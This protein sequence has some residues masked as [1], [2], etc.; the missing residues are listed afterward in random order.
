[1]PRLA[2]PEALWLL[3]LGVPIVWLGMRSLVVLE[4]F[5][6]WTAIGLRLAVLTVLVS[7]LAGLQSVQRHEHLTVMAVVD[8]SESVRRFATLPEPSADPGAPADA[9]QGSLDY[10]RWLERWLRLAGED[11][12]SDD[13]F[14]LMGFSDRPQLE[15]MPTKGVRTESAR[16][17]SGGDGTDISSALRSAMGLLPP[18][19]G[20]RL[21]LVSDGNHASSDLDPRSGF[22]DVL[23]AAREA[24]AAGIPVDVAPVRY[25]ARSEVLVEAVYAPTQARQGRTVGVRVAL[26][27]TAPTAGTLQLLHDEEM[28]DVNGPDRPGTGLSVA[29]S[30]WTRERGSQ[31]DEASEQAGQYVLV[32][33]VDVPVSMTG[34]NRFEAVFE[35]MSDSSAS[36]ASSAGGDQLAANNRAEGFTLVSGKGKV[37]VV[38]ALGGSSGEVLPSA[39]RSRGIDLDVVPPQGMP[40]RL[41][42]L[43]RYD[44]VVFQNVPRE[45]ITL[46]Q[47]R[48]LVRYVHDL[49]GGFVMVGGNDSFGAGGWTNSPVDQRL[50]PV[51]CQIPTQ[52]V[53]PTGALMLVIDRSGSMHSPVG[54]SNK[55]QIDLASE[56]AVLALQTLYPQDYVGV[57]SF[58]SRGHLVAP[59][60]PNDNPNALAKKIRSI[61]A[62]GGTSITPGLEMARKQLRQLKTTDAAVR[63]VILIT[64]GQSAPPPQNNWANAVGPLM[65]SGIT[66]S[67]VGVGDTRN[68]SLLQRVATMG[69]GE[70]HDI[71]NPGNLPQV[72]I[73]E[74]KTIRKSLIKE[75]EFTPKL[76]ATGSPVTRNLPGTPP[77]K[78]LV[79]TG[80]KRD[81]RVFQPMLGPEGEP[82]FAHWQTGLGRAAA[83]T[84]DAHNRWASDWLAWGGYPDFWGRTI[85]YVSRP[86]PTQSADLLTE[87]RGDRL[88]LRLDATSAGE[89]GSGG[90]SFD[91]YAEVR[92]GVI[93]PDG[94]VREVALEQTGPG[95]YEADIPAD[96]AGSYVVSLMLT[97]PDGTR[98]TVFGGANRPVNRELRQFRSNAAV[99][100]RVAEITGGRVLDPARPR[101]A[102]GGLYSREGYDF[103]TRSVQP[104]W[105]TLLIVLLVL[106]M[107]DVANR[108]VAWDPVG[109]WRWS[110]QRA[111][112]MLGILSRKDKAESAEPTMASLKAARQRAGSRFATAT[113]A[114]GSEG[115]AAVHASTGGNGKSSQAAVKNAETEHARPK[116]TAKFEAALE[117][118]ASDDFASAVGGA[119]AA[120]PT[121]VRLARASQPKTKTDADQDA[122]TTSRLMAAKRA[123][124]ERM[125]EE[126]AEPQINADHRR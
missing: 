89:D 104:L 13:R 5:R 84:S 69:G 83:F 44:A 102:G 94:E 3:L 107:L 29:P 112:A 60:A 4:P 54:G 20:A 11:R 79:L 100:E 17:A 59:L 2:H 96:R 114:A 101:V 85:R 42:R 97:E 66:V 31:P 122:G 40:S 118:E 48:N 21:V 109:I 39:L 45:M 74:A 53:L 115:K 125:T 22:E 8:R 62:G 67:T 110:L 9:V 113:A 36:V 35:P 7:M 14:G 49:G 124:R 57:V 95:L 65:Q 58:D 25:A 75:T 105:R 51:E 78:G 72:L 123:A 71:A 43:Q 52:T 19:S 86:T 92:G 23:A 80:P 88:R 108:R 93:S 61:R 1:M 103:V 56:A 64:D 87:I 30:Q 99:L 106:V 26:R 24:K 91:R 73:K 47:Q 18:D 50:L 33:R 37:L 111:D 70:Y 121:G 90:T 46:P 126:N 10:E 81:P 116:R 63:H 38:D 27:A 55:S 41:S 16:D 12:E 32:Q 120:D 76:V 28:L 15:V 77:L 119:S 34:V 6:Q 68:A 98:R 82:L 117:A